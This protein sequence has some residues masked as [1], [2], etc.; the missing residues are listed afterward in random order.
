MSVI[1]AHKSY[2]RP[3]SRRQPLPLAWLG[4]LMS[5]IGPI[6]LAVLAYSGQ[7]GASPI[8]GWLPGNVTLMS[9][10]V[11]VVSF[12][13]SVF[14]RQWVSLWT[15]VPLGL[16]L[17]FLFPVIQFV[18]G[19]Y[20]DQKITGL[21]M[22]GL[23]C[24]IAPFELL[25]LHMQRVAFLAALAVFGVASGV[26]TLM[27][28]QRA[29]LAAGLSSD[30]LLLDGA[31]T[32][33]TARLAGTGALILIAAALV[34]GRG[35]L[36]RRFWFVV[37]GLGLLV[38]MVATG[39]RGPL[40]GIIAG[41]A[42]LI[43]LVPAMR[44]RR[45]WSLILLGLG[46]ATAYAWASS[47]GYVSS[48]RAFAWL[49]GE[50]DT[51]TQA[52]E[53]LWGMATDYISRNPIGTGWGGFST[54][55][56]VPPGLGYPHNLFLEVFAEAGWIIGAVT[57]VFVT[58]SLWRLMRRSSEPVAAIMFVLAV[59]ALMNAM[60]S[61]DINDNRL[62]WILLGSAWVPLGVEVAPKNLAS[63]PTP[64]RVSA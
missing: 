2:V 25:R 4:P 27:G 28:G 59:F 6:A 51:S 20:Q 11:I 8:L 29:A 54:I 57:L 30:V 63:H 37:A 49:A 22:F 39:S 36:G 5:A 42:A 48:D 1:A 35:R 58:A 64:R 16:W 14:T 18:P 61:G 50:R 23:V 56:G 10:V 47:R 45:F 43:L 7:L 41:I 55:D 46:T 26:L 53:H 31:N 12:V 62:L 60:V 40:A 44:G 52:R 9:W 32:I 24:V 3:E 21:L 38:V 17:L 34:I 13:L 19:D 15:A 33:G